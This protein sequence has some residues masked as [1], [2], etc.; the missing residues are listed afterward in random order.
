MALHLKSIPE[1]NLWNERKNGNK[2]PYSFVS[3]YSQPHPDNDFID[4][5]ALTRNVANAIIND[6]VELPPQR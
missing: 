3:R 4:L 5:D 6:Q 1:F 2:A